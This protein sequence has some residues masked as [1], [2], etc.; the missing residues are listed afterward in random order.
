ME[1][2]VGG[3][4]EVPGYRAETLIAKVLRVGKKTVT[5]E[6][7]VPSTGVRRIKTF[8]VYAVKAYVAPS[9]AAA[10]EGF[11]HMTYGC[12]ICGSI[13]I[14]LSMKPSAFMAAHKAEVHG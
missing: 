3:L 13:R 10:A 11:H 5:T 2:E 7:A 8:P 1:L 4:A 6:Y 12:P 9:V 14:P